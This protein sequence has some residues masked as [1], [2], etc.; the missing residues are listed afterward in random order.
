MSQETED[1]NGEHAA[2]ERAQERVRVV[3][4]AE[5]LRQWTVNSLRHR[6][7][8]ARQTAARLRRSYQKSDYRHACELLA[9]IEDETARA[10]EAL[11]KV[12]T[13]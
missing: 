1:P 4:G 9:G 3:V 6:I 10:C 5:G 11:L 8:V 2:A 12:L 7:E 13:P